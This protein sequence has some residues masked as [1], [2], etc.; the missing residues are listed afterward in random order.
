MKRQLMTVVTAICYPDE[1]TFDYWVTQ[2]EGGT[3]FDLLGCQLGASVAIAN[4][5][6]K[7]VDQV[8]D[9]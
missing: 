6:Q 3:Q 2:S 5:L 8:L 9:P 4:Q 1:G 7:V